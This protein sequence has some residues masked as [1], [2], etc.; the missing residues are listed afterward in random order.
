MLLF[1]CLLASV[2]L[3]QTPY[4]NHVDPIF[5]ALPLKAELH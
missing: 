1:R 3:P 5:N 4:L 2:Y